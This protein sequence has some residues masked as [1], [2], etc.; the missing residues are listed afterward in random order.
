MKI[1]HPWSAASPGWSRHHK[2]SLSAWCSPLGL[3]GREEKLTVILS[4]HILGSSSCEWNEWRWV[5]WRRTDCFTARLLR[6][7]FGSPVPIKRYCCQAGEIKLPGNWQFL[8]FPGDANELAYTISAARGRITSRM[9][10]SQCL[11]NP[12]RYARFWILGW[13]GNREYAGTE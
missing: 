13:E 9:K 6:T 4:A 7:L 10:S 1:G 3:E 5:D 12:E 11:L 2:M 8:Q